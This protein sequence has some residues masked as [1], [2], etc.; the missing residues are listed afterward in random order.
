MVAS[1]VYVTTYVY[2]MH[3]PPMEQ[4]SKTDAV[5]FCK[6]VLYQIHAESKY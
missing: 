5:A 4:E 3:M 2:K 1:T 6:A